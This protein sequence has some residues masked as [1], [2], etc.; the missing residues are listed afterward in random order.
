[1][2]ESRP[3]HNPTYQIKH[4]LTGA[5]VIITGALAVLLLLFREPAQ[6]PDTG[7]GVA[8][9]TGE[10][11]E[12]PGFQSNLVPLNVSSVNL[13]EEKSDPAENSAQSQ[14][15][16][17]ETGDEKPA[18][19]QDP[20]DHSPDVSGE[21]LSGWSVR[22]GTFM[23][24]ENVDRL[25]TFLGDHGFDAKLTRVQVESGEATRVWLGPYAKRETAD[26]VNAKLL[27]L[28]GEKGYVTKH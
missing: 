11:A 9:S 10:E 16:Q 1:M 12:T 7:V 27:A 28:R 3:K 2:G 21:A 17:G 8:T 19:G 4:R 13:N 25:F 18:N 15:E 26:T 22:V 6:M 20:A 5:A 24:Q 14:L 23:K